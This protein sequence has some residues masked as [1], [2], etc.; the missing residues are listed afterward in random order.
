MKKLFQVFLR[1]MINATS[2]ARPKECSV[3]PYLLSDDDA[4]QVRA[5]LLTHAELQDRE[6][7]K[8]EELHGRLKKD[9]TTDEELDVVEDIEDQ[10]ED[11]TGDTT[12]LKRI[13][14]IFG[15]E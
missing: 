8:A 4:S 12:N 11:L 14:K 1:R 10:I 3:T 5:I 6:T 9:A 2:I 7:V 15:D 13:A